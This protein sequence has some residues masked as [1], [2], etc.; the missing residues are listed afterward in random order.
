MY[1]AKLPGANEE[2]KGLLHE[3]QE[4]VRDPLTSSAER[5]WKLS[6]PVFIK[7]KI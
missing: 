2:K 7:K 4:R 6:E 3:L 1:N 5:L